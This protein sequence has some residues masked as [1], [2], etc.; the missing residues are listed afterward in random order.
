MTI[1]VQSRRIVAAVCV[2]A[3]LAEGRRRKKGAGG[4]VVFFIS[5]RLRSPFSISQYIS[6]PPR[7]PVTVQH[8]G[9]KY[10]HTAQTAADLSRPPKTMMRFIFVCLFFFRHR[11]LVRLYTQRKSGPRRRSVGILVGVVTTLCRIPH[12][13]TLPPHDVYSPPIYII[14]YIII[15]ALIL[16]CYYY[17]CIYNRNYV[18]ATVSRNAV[19]LPLDIALHYLKYYIIVIV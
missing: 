3:N 14:L 2:R 10:L 18:F 1:H 12:V 5:F 8:R 16:Y 15:Y 11:R 13:P 19:L 9:P 4:R 6:Q 17:Y 7:K